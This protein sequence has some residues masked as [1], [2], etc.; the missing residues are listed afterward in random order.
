MEQFLLGIEGK[1]T[2]QVSENTTRSIRCLGKRQWSYMFAYLDVFC[3]ERLASVMPSSIL[4]YDLRGRTAA[5]FPLPD[6]S[7]KSGFTETM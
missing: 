5:I 2:A 7:Q 6:K 3:W 1:T 4:M